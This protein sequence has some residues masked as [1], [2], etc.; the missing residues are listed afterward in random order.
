MNIPDCFYRVSVKALVLNETKDKFLVCQEDNGRWELPGGG[1]DFGQSVADEMKREIKE[2]MGLEVKRMAD[3][4]CYFITAKMTRSEGWCVNVLFEVEL[5]SLD[6]TPSNECQA[7]RFINK[8]DLPEIEVFS[9]VTD[10]ANMFN[11][12]NH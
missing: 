5:V 3:N 4:P 6:F 8:T 10:L 1:L 7:I 12:K 2:E 9:T 11:P